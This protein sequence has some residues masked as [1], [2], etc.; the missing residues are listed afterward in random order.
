MVVCLSALAV[1]GVPHLLPY[2]SWDRLQH[3][4]DPGLDKQIRMDGW[5]EFYYELLQYHVNSRQR[6]ECACLG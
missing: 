3:P 4:W 2:V 5:I 6:R 1:Q